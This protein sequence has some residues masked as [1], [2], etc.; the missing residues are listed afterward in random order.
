MDA[1]QVVDVGGHGLEDARDHFVGLIRA[2]DEQELRET[3]G[4]SSFW[5]E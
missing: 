3:V 4:Q 1:V 2:G 5:K